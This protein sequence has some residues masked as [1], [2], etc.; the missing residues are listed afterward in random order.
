MVQPSAGVK[1]LA[2][3]S[4]DKP[5]RIMGGFMVSFYQHAGVSISM[6]SVD[7]EMDPLV[8]L[9]Q[10]N[11]Q[12]TIKIKPGALRSRWR[13]RISWRTSRAIFAD[14]TCVINSIHYCDRRQN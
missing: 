10:K 14:H 2:S 3:C 6:Y 1:L 4:R 11:F 13:I 5:G 7:M 9:L 8:Y 12:L